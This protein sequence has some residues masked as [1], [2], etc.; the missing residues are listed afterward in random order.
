MNAELA[1]T[2][3]IIIVCALVV[4]VAELRNARQHRKGY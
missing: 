1:A 2:I 4:L 3:A